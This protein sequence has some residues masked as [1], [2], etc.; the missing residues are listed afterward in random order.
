MFGAAPVAIGWFSRRF[1]GPWT[2]F[3]RTWKALAGAGA[4]V[5]AGYALGVV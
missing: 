2:S 1:D 5:F 4:A 3:S